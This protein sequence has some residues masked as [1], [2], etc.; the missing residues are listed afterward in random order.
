MRTTDLGKLRSLASC[1]DSDGF[2][3]VLAV[4]HPVSFILGRKDPAVADDP[5]SRARAVMAKWQLTRALA[6]HASALL[7]DPDLGLAA[8]LATGALPGRIG[9]IMCAEA[10]G[11]QSVADAHTVTEL[12]P[13]WDARK[14]RLAGGDGLKLLWRYRG[15]VPEAAAHRDLVRRVADECAAVS[16]PLIV[17]PI[18]VPLEGEDL[19]DPQVRARRVRGVVDTAVLAQELG[20]DLVKTEFPGWVGSDQERESGSAACS[21]ID[22]ALDVPWLLLSAGVTFEQFMVQTEIAAKEGSAGFIAGRAVWDVAGAE[23]AQVREAGIVV[24]AERLAR[25]TAVVHAHGRP[26]RITGDADSALHDYP[27]GWYSGW[28]NLQEG[29][30]R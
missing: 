11:Y 12:R 6:P 19:D 25:L 22:A 26:W 15:E 23:D 7:T 3:T 4:D 9:L 13:G 1:A 28:H 27:P 20:A 18:W 10:E 2:F 30:L 17:E 5:D 8:A 21:E 29:S 14:I 24:A 16:L